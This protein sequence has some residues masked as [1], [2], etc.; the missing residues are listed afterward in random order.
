MRI[1]KQLPKWDLETKLFDFFFIFEFYTYVH[2][3]D[4]LGLLIQAM[5]V[6]AE[7]PSEHLIPNLFTIVRWLCEQDQTAIPLIIST[8]QMLYSKFLKDNFLFILT[9]QS[10][11]QTLSLV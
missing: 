5:L 1:L 6:K 8:H 4:C 2:S 10:I 9:A 3:L 11:T 7:H